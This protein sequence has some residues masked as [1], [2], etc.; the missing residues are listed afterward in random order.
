MYL[1]LMSSGSGTKAKEQGTFSK[2]S[3]A[4]DGIVCYN[5]KELSMY[6]K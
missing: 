2:L 3:L 5:S 4:F 6:L 1:Y